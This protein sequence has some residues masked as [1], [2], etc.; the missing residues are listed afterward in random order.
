MAM[1]RSRVVCPQCRQSDRTYK[2]SLLYLESVARLHHQETTN[3]PELD[4]LLED[5]YPDDPDSPAQSQ[6]MSHLVKTLAP[7][8][9]EKRVTRRIH[10]DS[11]V[12]FFGLFTLIFLYQA[13]ASRSGQFPI[14]AVLTA[15]SLLAYAIARKKIIHRF[16]TRVQQEQE[17]NERIERAIGS[18]MKLYLCSRDQGV[19]NPDT[20]S[21]ASIE[22]VHRLLE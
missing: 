10:P 3:Q 12:I 19:F 16:T 8:E 14:L 1:T 13:A 21:F 5:L 18:W 9:G 6:W 11:M 15:A 7:P 17:E 20:D 22:N 2:V 4:S